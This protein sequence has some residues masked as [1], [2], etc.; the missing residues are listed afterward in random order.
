MINKHITLPDPMNDWIEHLVRSGNYASDSD[1][2]ADLIRRD[3]VEHN[4]QE[5]QDAI[6][7]G[8]GSGPATPLDMNAIKGQAR[9][10]AGLDANDP[11][12]STR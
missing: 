6:T 5:L 12:P 2:I 1:Y 8:L 7:E 4:L 10:M 9:A 11:H 3:Q